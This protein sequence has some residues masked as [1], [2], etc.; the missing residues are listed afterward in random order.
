MVVAS[1]RGDSNVA[2]ADHVDDD[3]IPIRLDE[4]SDSGGAHVGDDV[5]RDQD[6][7][8][9]DNDPDVIVALAGDIAFHH[10]PTSPAE[11]RAEDDT[12]DARGRR[13]ESPDDVP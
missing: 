6:F 3:S 13:A 9:V 11:P 10:V 8:D 4:D 2:G 1:K 12:E 7:R 5:V